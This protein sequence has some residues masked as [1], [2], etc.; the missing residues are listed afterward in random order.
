MTQPDGP[1][2]EV[3]GLL[4]RRAVAADLPLIREIKLAAYDVYE[5]LLGFQAMPVTADYG[6]YVATGGAWLGLLEG[7][8]IAALVTELGTRHLLIYSLAVRP[9]WQ[10][11][12]HARTMLDHAEAQARLAGCGELRLSTNALMHRNIALY[13]HCGFQEC[14]R[15]AHPHRAGHEVVDMTRV[16]A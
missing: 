9:D 3:R 11:E 10:G 5:P 14:G 4:V 15:R 16:L 6:P 8:A 1:T 13:R 2:H 12:G 7:E